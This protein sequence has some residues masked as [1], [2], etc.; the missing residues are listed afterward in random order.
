M[1]IEYLLPTMFEKVQSCEFCG[2][3]MKI[4]PLD[5]AENPFCRECIRLR[6]TMISPGP[7]E[8]MLT[9]GEYIVFIHRAQQKPS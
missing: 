6:L 9:V 2:R 8:Q 3:E 5:Y 1:S 4:P 7:L